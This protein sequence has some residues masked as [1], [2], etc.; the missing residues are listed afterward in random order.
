MYTTIMVPLDGSSFGEHALPLALNTVRRSGAALQLVYVHAG[1]DHR[2]D[3]AL[4]PPGHEQE[5]EKH[6]QAAIDE[7]RVHRV[8]RRP[9]KR[10]RRGADAERALS[11]GRERDFDQSGQRKE[12]PAPYAAG[13]RA[14]HGLSG[15]VPDSGE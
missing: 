7:M 9:A 5:A 14:A 10:Q 2:P 8:N 6:Q 15:D 12:S 4:L 3:L 13:V 11:E 1:D